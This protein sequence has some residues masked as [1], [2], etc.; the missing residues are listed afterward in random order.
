MTE[1]E[2]AGLG[3][4]FA[5]FLRPYRCCF[6]SVETARHFDNYCRGLLSD[7]PRKSVEPIALAS[8][9]TVRTMQVFLAD[10]PWDH[11]EAERMFHRQMAE[12]VAQ[13]PNDGVGTI[14]V[15]DETSCRKWGDKTPGVQRQY[16][17]CVGKID[18]GVVTVHVGVAKGPFQSLL[19][20]DLYLPESWATDRQRCRE[21]GIPDTMDYRPKWKIAFD[22][23]TRLGEAGHRFDW[24][25]FDEGYG[26]KV[27]FLEALS[28]VQQKFV[29]EV[30]VNFMI[31]KGARSRR[32]DQVL[33]ARHARR[34]QRIRLRRKTQNDAIWRVVD[35][36][37]QVNDFTWRLIVAISEATAEVKYFVTN[38]LD[39]PLKKVFRV[40]FRRAT[41]EHSFRLAKQEAGL[42]HFEGRH[43]Q[44]LERHLL[45]SLLVI[46]FVA[47]HTERLRGEKSGDHSGTSV[48]RPQRPLRS[49]PATPKRPLPH[50]PSQ[51]RHPLPSAA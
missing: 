41:I 11:D 21:A 31:H 20:A 6:S 7:L 44:A 29:G 13:Q 27:P 33:T 45:M 24:L 10:R 42:T 3:G 37:I 17:G 1:Q 25:T 39:T 46:G 8:G 28:I 35:K 26:S 30:P 15:I 38:D 18:N 40:A 32:V 51:P 50:R 19:M 47:V 22:Q 49:T 43:Y 2:M 23:W 48:P 14:G 5:E 36:R 4:A 9:T 16:L 12:Q 34:G